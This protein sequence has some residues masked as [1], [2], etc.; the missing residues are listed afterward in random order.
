MNDRTKREIETFKRLTTAAELT[1][2]NVQSALGDETRIREM[3]VSQY[4]VLSA[5]ADGGSM[6]IREL[7]RRILRSPGNMT[8]IVHNLARDGY[9]ALQPGE[10][11]RRTVTVI[12]TPLGREMVR[13]TRPRYNRRIKNALGEL[14]DRELKDLFG[15]C[16]VLIAANE[17]YST[18]APEVSDK[19]KKQRSEK[20]RSK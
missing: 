11:D 4:G 13:F 15:V 8:L 18:A 9:I 5:L 1:S 16:D 14:T 6:I 3:T 19:Q 12:L 17:E 2:M 20:G 7:G 10:T